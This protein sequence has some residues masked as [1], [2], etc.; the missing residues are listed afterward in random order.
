M[1]VG[2]QAVGTVTSSASKSGLQAESGSGLLGYKLCDQPL[3][4]TA[5]PVLSC[6]GN[7]V[8]SFCPQHRVTLVPVEE[9]ST[10]FVE[11]R[12]FCVSTHGTFNASR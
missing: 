4:P 5:P 2:E 6:P 8:S 7:N 11:P 12:V 1:R 10:E 3:C 9:F